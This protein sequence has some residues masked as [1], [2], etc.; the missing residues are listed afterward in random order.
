MLICV[1]M[2][3]QR[4]KFQRNLFNPVL[5]TSMYKYETRI[6]IRSFHSLT[7]KRN[8]TCDLQKK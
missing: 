3:L 2:G 4:H 6:E 1:L 8:I 7:Q 5:N